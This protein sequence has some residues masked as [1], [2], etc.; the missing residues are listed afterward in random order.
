MALRFNDTLR[1]SL[2][3]NLRSYIDGICFV[4]PGTRPPNP[5][6]PTSELPLVRF[7]LQ[8]NSAANGAITLSNSPVASEVEATGTATWFRLEDGNY[9][10]DGDVSTEEGGG[11][12]IL[13]NVSL[14]AGEMVTLKQMDFAIPNP[15]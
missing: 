7:T 13:D 9:K 12:A 1:N 2:M 4:Y 10:I 11:D 15:A 3:N 5:D 6:F 8:Y 14:T